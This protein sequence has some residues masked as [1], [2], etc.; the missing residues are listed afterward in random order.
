M[1]FL[2][3][4]RDLKCHLVVN[5]DK[6]ISSFTCLRRCSNLK[7]KLLTFFSLHLLLQLTRMFSVKSMLC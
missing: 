6:I 5:A 7:K 3:K 1:K 2:G 4:F